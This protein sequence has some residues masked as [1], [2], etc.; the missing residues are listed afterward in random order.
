MYAGAPAFTIWTGIGALYM[1]KAG[2]DF[3]LV[4]LRAG[5]YPRGGGCIRAAI[6]AVTTIRPFVKMER[7]RLCSV[8]GLSQ[9]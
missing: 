3:E 7:G 9:Q 6:D 8:S 4:L 1:Q 2:F 5:F